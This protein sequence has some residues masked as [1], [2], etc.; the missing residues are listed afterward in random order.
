MAF[1]RQVATAQRS[2]PDVRS[3][4]FCPKRAANLRRK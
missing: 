3:D 2:D 4:H 1:Q